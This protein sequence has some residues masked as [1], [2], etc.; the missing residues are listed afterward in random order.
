MIAHE[1]LSYIGI[2]LSASSQLVSQINDHE[3][4]FRVL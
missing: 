3:D 1:I 4:G 2:D